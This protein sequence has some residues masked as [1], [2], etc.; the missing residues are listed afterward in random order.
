MVVA[1][2][3]SLFWKLSLPIGGVLILR[4][5]AVAISFRILIRG[6]GVKRKLISSIHSSRKRLAYLRDTH[7]RLCY[8]NNL[9]QAVQQFY[10]P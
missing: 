10:L 5:I 7:A 3:R 6:A 1:F 9:Q 4:G 2:S 8:A